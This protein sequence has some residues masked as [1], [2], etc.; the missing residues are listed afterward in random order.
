MPFSADLTIESK[1]LRLSVRY[2]IPLRCV[3]AGRIASRGV[4]VARP[5]PA[6]GLV[7]ASGS[8]GVR[9]VSHANHENW[10]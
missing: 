8:D 4:A 3:L 7:T 10:L 1:R 2:A 5:S 9:M 6:A